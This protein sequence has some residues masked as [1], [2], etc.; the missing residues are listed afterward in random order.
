MVRSI[1]K[2]EIIGVPM[3]LGSKP[4]GVEMG[5]MAVGYDG[6]HTAFR[7]IEAF[8]SIKAI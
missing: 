2:V 1:R 8:F 4:L 7:Y 3:D 5:P 6:L